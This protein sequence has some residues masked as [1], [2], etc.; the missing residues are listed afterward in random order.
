[1]GVGSRLAESDLDK[2]LCFLFLLMHRAAVAA[3]E[4]G[5][6]RKPGVGALARS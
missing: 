6:Q 4:G 3:F 5:E 1:M 2:A